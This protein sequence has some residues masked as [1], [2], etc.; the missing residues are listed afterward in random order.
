[1]TYALAHDSQLLPETVRLVLFR[2]LQEAL[3]NI[4]RHA[5]ASQVNIRFSFDAEEAQLEIADNG[6]GFTVP[7]SWLDL[8]HAGHYGLV[9]MAERVS[10]AGGTLEIESAPGSSTTIR[11]VVPYGKI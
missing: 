5:E 8:L 6:K 9:G 10:A 2:V 11:V 3:A 7:E 4:V 1:M